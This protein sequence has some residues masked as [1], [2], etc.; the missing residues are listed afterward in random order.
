M[1]G[2]GQTSAPRDPAAYD[3]ITL[4]GDIQAAMDQ[5]GHTQVCVVGHDWGGAVAFY[6]AYDNRELVER[7][8]ILDMVPGLIRAGEAF[9]LDFAIKI[10]HVFFHGG[11]PDWATA[12]ITQNVDLYLRRFLT[13]L[14]YNYSPAVFSEEDIAEYVRVNSLPGSIRAGMQ[15]YAAGLRQDAVNL[16]NA[17][18]KLT[19]PLLA[20]MNGTRSLTVFTGKDGCTTSSCGERATSA[21]EAKSRSVS[22][23]YLTSKGL[24]E[25]GL[26]L[27]TRIV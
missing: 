27:P 2:Y 25:I 26:A 7:L 1:R 18:E 15:W 20:F 9:P 11:N 3:V 12:L 21:I 8:C 5:L 19:L 10:N 16:A 4:C 22:Y 13:T 14:D 23:W 17:T 24:I 6:L